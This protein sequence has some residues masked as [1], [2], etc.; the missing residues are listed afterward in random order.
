MSNGQG[1][2]VLPE[3]LLRGDGW[4][5]QLWSWSNGSAGQR[6]MRK[7][8]A[9]LR[10]NT[11]CIGVLAIDSRLIWQPRKLVSWILTTVQCSAERILTG[12]LLP[13]G[14]WRVEH[15]PENKRAQLCP[16]LWWAGSGIEDSSKIRTFLKMAKSSFDVVQAKTVLDWPW[17]RERW[18]YRSLLSL[19]Q[20]SLDYCSA[21]VK[22]N[23]HYPLSFLGGSQIKQF[24]FC[25]ISPSGKVCP[26]H[27]RPPHFRNSSKS[28]LIQQMDIH[29]IACG[30][31][32]KLQETFL[33][34]RPS[35]ESG[36]WECF[37]CSSREQSN[38]IWNF[39]WVD[40]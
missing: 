33:K 13:A 17:E 12:S 21:W 2:N 32:C 14:R 34:I 15:V 11:S 8:V 40:K 26:P 3:W 4:R 9:D 31:Q 16:Q 23:V 25:D 24:S 20:R 38:S 6:V 28:R 19:D 27:S 30:A 22:P 7:R 10:R 35:M 37:E 5:A 18:T 29:N 1:R 39:N 36:R